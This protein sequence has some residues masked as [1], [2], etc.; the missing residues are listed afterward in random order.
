MASSADRSAARRHIEEIRASLNVDN[1]DRRTDELENLLN[2]VA[3]QLYRESTHFLLEILQNADDNNYEHPTPTLK[4]TC[5]EE[6]F[7]IDSN[8]VGFTDKDVKAVC[9]AGASNKAGSSDT[10]GE[11]GLGFKA[12]FKV[13]D[14]VWIASR[15]YS[16]KFDK[17][18]KLG[19]IAPE[20]ADE[21]PVSL[22]DGYSTIYLHLWQC[23]RAEIE[24]V[25]EFDPALLPFL[26]KVERIEL[27]RKVEH[28]RTLARR[29][30]RI[31]DTL[32]DL[33]IE[34]DDQEMLRYKIIEYEIPS[35]P[36]ETKRPGLSECSVSLGFPVSGFEVAKSQ[37]VY[38][39]LPIREYGFTFAIQA[40]FVLIANR[41]DIDASSAW[42]IKIR[43]FV[44]GA[45]INAVNYFNTT[46]FRYTWPRFLPV[47]TRDFF[48]PVAGEIQ[49][50][51]KEKESFE[52]EDG[53]MHEPPSLVYVG[54]YYRLDDTPLVLTDF[55]KPRYLSRRYKD[56]RSETLEHLGIKELEYGDFLT[57]L[58]I[59][60][61]KEEK[62]FRNQSPQWFSRLA[63]V[64]WL[65]DYKAPNRLATLKIIPLSNGEWTSRVESK[66]KLFYLPTNDTT[67]VPKGT[68]VL[69]VGPKAEN[70]SER[71]RL[72]TSL[73]AKPFS[74]TEISSFV[75]RLHTMSSVMIQQSDLVDHLVFLFS[76]GWSNLDDV[77]LW[78]A[79]GSGY[80]RA[81]EVYLRPFAPNGR[82]FAFPV[83]HQDYWLATAGRELQ[84][85]HWLKDQLRICEFPRLVRMMGDGFELSEDMKRIIEGLPSG[86][87]L[88]LLRDHW[89][90][91]SEWLGS[92]EDL[93]YTQDWILSKKALRQCLMSTEVD[94]ING[95]RYSLKDT[96]FPAGDLSGVEGSDALPLLDIPNSSNPSW[97][98]LEQLGVT[99][100]CDVNHYLQCLRTIKQKGQPERY[101]QLY[102]KIQE[103]ID[104]DLPSTKEAFMQDSLIYIPPRN[105]RPYH[106]AAV[107]DCVW[108]GQDSLRRIHS[109]DYIYPGYARLF[110][111]VLDI[112]NAGLDTF[113]A[114]ARR[115]TS[116][117]Q[118]DYIFRLLQ[119]IN[120][121]L[122]LD[123]SAEALDSVR[124]LR[125][126]AIFPVKQKGSEKLTFLS[127]MDEWF[128]ADNQRLTRKLSGKIPLLALPGRGIQRLEKLVRT[129]EIDQHFL[130]R[131]ARRK[132]EITGNPWFCKD[133]TDTLSAK[134]RFIAC[135]IPDRQRWLWK[136][137]RE[138]KVYGVDEIATELIVT[139]SGSD[140]TIE[141]SQSR[142]VITVNKDDSLRVYLTNRD[143]EEPF[144]SPE[145]FEQLS[146]QLLIFLGIPEAEKMRL[147]VILVYS[148]PR[149]IKDYLD[150]H[151]VHLVDIQ[152][153]E[154][155][156]QDTPGA[157]L[158]THRL[159]PRTPE[160]SK[161]VTSAFEGI[162]DRTKASR[163]PMTSGKRHSTSPAQDRS[164]STSTSS[165]SKSSPYGGNVSTPAELAQKE[166]TG[167]QKETAKLQGSLSRIGNKDIDDSQVRPMPDDTEKE[168]YIASAKEDFSAVRPLVEAS[169]KLDYL[170][171]LNEI[172]QGIS[173]MKKQERREET[174][175]YT[176][177]QELRSHTETLFWPQDPVSLA[178]AHLLEQVSPESI[179]RAASVAVRAKGRKQGSDKLLVLNRVLER[180]K[181][182]RLTGLNDIIYL[183]TPEEL[184]Q[185]DSGTGNLRGVRSL[186]ARLQITKNGE[187]VLY[188]ALEPGNSIDPEPML[189]GEVKISRLLEDVLGDAYQPD[190]HWTST[191]RRQLNH[192]PFENSIEET[193]TF[194]VDGDTRPLTE[195]L[196][197]SSYKAAE[198]WRDHRPVYHIEVQTSAGGLHSKFTMSSAKVD[199]ARKHKISKLP[200]DDVFVLIRIHDI[201]V[202]PGISFFVDPWRLY[203]AGR[204]DFHVTSSYTANI[205]RARPHILFTGQAGGADRDILLT[206]QASGYTQ[207]TEN[208]LYRWKPLKHERFIRLLRLS[209]GHGNQELSGTLQHVSLDDSPKYLAISY[210]WGSKLQQFTL[211]T[212][213][214][215]IPLTLSLYLGLRQIRRTDRSI[216]IWAD[217]ISIN[218][219]DNDEKERQVRLMQDIFRSAVHVYAWLGQG[220]SESSLAME[221][222]RKISASFDAEEEGSQS[223]GSDEIPPVEDSSWVAISKL[224]RRK[225]FRRVWIVQEVILASQLT[226]VCGDDRIPWRQFYEAAKYCDDQASDS[227]LSVVF[228]K[229]GHQT[230]IVSLGEFKTSY[231]EGGPEARQD[232][233]TLLRVFKLTESTSRRDKLFALLS[234]A[235]D[236]TTKG[237]SPDYKSRFKDVV[238]QY[239]KVF[240]E[241]QGRGIDLL[242]QARLSATPGK[243][244][245]PSWIPSWASPTAYPETMSNWTGAGHFRAGTDKTAEMQI[246]EDILSVRGQVVDSVAKIGKWTSTTDMRRY[247]GEIFA[248]ID[249]LRVDT[250]EERQN[251]KWKVPIGAAT[252]PTK[253]DW[254][255]DAG[256]AS[257]RAMADYLEFE[258][259]QDDSW[260]RE[261]RKI[262]VNATNPLPLRQ[263]EILLQQ[264]WP[265]LN[266][267]MDFA[268]ILSPAVA[269]TTRG[270]RVGIVPRTAHE[271][272]VVAVF[273]GCAVPFLLRKRD[274]GHNRHYQVVGEC[275]VH[276]IMHGEALSAH[277]PEEHVMLV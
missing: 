82:K 156:D 256:R 220:D 42:N 190:R 97:S 76:A 116:D 157:S 237:F 140:L 106:W 179:V 50:K 72:F 198:A 265:Y 95:S 163:K 203:S 84:W 177:G 21:F 120:T 245:L 20:W 213:E 65:Y 160:R 71:S 267:A 224:F 255:D 117:D 123:D 64:L 77:D 88:Q 232:L 66:D 244:S 167:P 115:I 137:V 152:E 215:G 234:L 214:G 261:Q 80:R 154:S 113:V 47:E 243:S 41:E 259:G 67:L 263:L 174:V 240:V 162:A 16:F 73:G 102:G 219:N 250:A 180:S 59:F 135:L 142:A 216:D 46:S 6:S 143:I 55:T 168:F 273:H 96:I 228:P 195:L 7:R 70:D 54:E 269:C 200:P 235:K 252:K 166:I 24:K 225:W 136:R 242:Y 254:G 86:Q 83:L 114:E 277:S 249:D 181:G 111:Q 172:A 53:E 134:A 26:R 221:A 49:E 241:E 238:L 122:V 17:K 38:A 139:V 204:I 112:K 222:L 147:W 105:G 150:G 217:A 98:F 187:R 109:L 158:P 75:V 4:L 258:E 212:K 194:T 176:A 275:Y 8:E 197:R 231:E 205:E 191:M 227:Q 171:P 201:N 30:E 45:F 100:K 11:K 236:G 266:T 185:V 22:L 79:T 18:K 209:A 103:T 164:K 81:S 33:I 186:P 149:K 94:C 127:L 126:C 272:D 69:F 15:A 93:N 61:E 110:S 248:F 10:T 268:E 119:M 91:Y 63:H 230:A 189:L 23:N 51:L 223:L 239:A 264:L 262:R 3:T 1:P 34:E 44:S 132:V 153:L 151:D 25:M 68:E 128:V 28:A 144:F 90:T 19:M 210:A 196:I 31:S 211:K 173:S 133:H 146:E 14:T 182:L 130:S 5:T 104:T 107:K 121:L 13:A 202:I 155:Y 138:M 101:L 257:F 125:G 35:M 170:L 141:S 39:F 99:M 199:L 56:L 247:L 188:I 52:G 145:L 9:S 37:P 92:D 251:L 276:G 89:Q 159:F 229:N 165:P 218:Q 85:T 270:Q 129:L 27:H 207:P 226:L 192:T 260:K 169:P 274:D 36:L 29:Q 87:F 206:L 43:D 118:P 57:D 253:G 208:P 193:T 32:Y 148:D 12:V 175:E 233:H 183:P 62:K 271:E 74:L 184:P 124:S 58:E 60:M 40:N 131:N 48:Q 2:I 108:K 78:V 246:S 161:E 178:P